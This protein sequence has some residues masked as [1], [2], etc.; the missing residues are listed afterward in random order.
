M[1][2]E[3][4][5]LGEDEESEGAGKGK[6]KQ[7]KE[8]KAKEPK[9]PKAVQAKGGKPGEK[10]VFEKKK[11]KKT[12]VII[13]I[14]VVVL[15]LIAAF[16]TLIY[17]NLF[18]LGEIV[19]NPISDWLIGVV[20]WMNPEFKSVEQELKT[21]HDARIEQLAETEQE[22]SKREEEVKAREDAVNTRET[23]LDR[24][25]AA[26]DR[27]E[28]QQA[29]EERTPAFQR[30]LTDSELADFRSLSNTFAQMPPASAAVILMEMYR[31]E[32]LATIIYFMN[33]R[34]AAAVLAEMNPLVAALIAEYLLDPV[35]AAEK[36]ADIESEYE[37]IRN[38]IVVVEEPDPEE[39]E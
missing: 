21:V 15:V 18:G 13:I 11:G 14:V 7:P 3:I 31:P 22:L 26:L 5:D 32:D 37:K 17:F 6:K 27:R 9:A 30:I 16:G 38:S 10:F 24:R 2:E 34:N 25:S 29:L 39:E 20:V 33:D 28:E 1:A 35:F 4:T 23:Q 19:L 12:L 36:Y 8:K